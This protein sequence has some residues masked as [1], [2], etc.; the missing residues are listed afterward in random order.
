M[1]NESLISVTEF[2]SYHH[3]DIQFIQLLERMG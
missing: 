3:L 2:C 1:E